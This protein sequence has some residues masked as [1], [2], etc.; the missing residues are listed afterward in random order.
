MKLLYKGNIRPVARN[1]LALVMPTP[2]FASRRIAVSGLP[3]S[4]TSWLAKALSLAPRVSYYFEPDYVLDSGYWYKYLSRD[5]TDS[6][7]D[8]LCM[9]L[10]QVKL[11]MNMSLQSKKFGKWQHMSF[12]MLYW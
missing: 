11:I 4:G 6:V 8:R 7:L 1:A 2:R 9:L 3:R 10:L 5:A 12:P